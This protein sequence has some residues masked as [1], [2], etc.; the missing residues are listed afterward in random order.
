MYIKQEKYCYLFKILYVCI[1]YKI[2]FK[3][4]KQNSK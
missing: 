1:L 2:I 3:I 4:L